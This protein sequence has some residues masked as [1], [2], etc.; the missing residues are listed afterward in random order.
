[1]LNQSVVDFY[2]RCPECYSEETLKYNIDK[3][4]C[5]N[6]GF[7][8]EVRFGIPVLI[9][10]KE[11]GSHSYE[12][13][14]L[15]SGERK[16]KSPYK[17]RSLN[18]FQRV[19]CR[20]AVHFFNTLYFIFKLGLKKMLL[21]KHCRVVDRALY[22]GW[23]NYFNLILKAGE[24]VQF[25]RMNKYIMEPSLEIGCADSRTT[26]MIFEDSIKSIT[27]GCEYFMD[28]FL[29][30]KEGL[31][32]EMFKVIKYYV[33]GS[34]RALP[35]RTGIFNSIIMV[36]IIDHIVDIG[37]GLKEISRILKPGGY[38]VMTGFSKYTFENLPGVRLRKIFSKKWSNRYK[39]E[40]LAKNNPRGSPLKSDFEYDATGQ[41]IF[42]IEEWRG[43]A[44][45]YGFE[46]KDY[47]FFGKYFSYFKD[48]EYRGYH[49][50]ILFN[51]FIYAAISEIIERERRRPL[52][53]EASTNIILVL[54]KV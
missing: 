41:N 21:R 23:K 42:S 12:F 36:H 14:N 6:C 50:S 1:M 5:N 31:S 48:I 7:K 26:N 10:N 8:P 19:F 53:E 40:R 38:L 49:N 17:K 54:K 18:L 34:F 16:V 47:G 37:Q 20:E 9:A 51:R 27:F 22:Y 32:D 29:N 35:F 46:V 43:I 39:E 28:N 15:P 30:G 2:L 13:L 4:V 24:M 25:N 3:M 44:K 11:T 33:G 52:S 45:A